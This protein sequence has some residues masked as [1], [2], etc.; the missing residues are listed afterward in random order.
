MKAK[1]IQKVVIAVKATK[2]SL[3]SSD[4]TLKQA[5]EE[6]EFCVYSQDLRLIMD[7]FGSKMGAEM[8]AKENGYEVTSLL[9]AT[10]SAYMKEGETKFRVCD[11]D[12]YVLT[13]NFTTKAEAEVWASEQG[14]EV[15]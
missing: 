6:N 5:F 13:G 3:F 11:H 9:L 15:K 10:I 1:E 4:G 12:G 7:N 14:Y 2:V 8:W